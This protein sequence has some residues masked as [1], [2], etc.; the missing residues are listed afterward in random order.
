MIQKIRFSFVFSKRDLISLDTII[1]TNPI[2]FY[3]D[4]YTTILI[5]TYKKTKHCITHFCFS[6]GANK[7]DSPSKTFLTNNN[8]GPRTEVKHGGYIERRRTKINFIFRKR[9]IEIVK[10]FITKV[11]ERSC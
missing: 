8:L 3:I 6:M 11:K 1:P 5:Y 4:K 10:Y 7:N 9:I 2:F